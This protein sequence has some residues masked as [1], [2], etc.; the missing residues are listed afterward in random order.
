LFLHQATELKKYA[1]YSDG[2]KKSQETGERKPWRKPFCRSLQCMGNDL[3]AEGRDGYNRTK[4]TV[5]AKRS[6][7]RGRDR[8]GEKNPTTF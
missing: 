1:A 7:K 2:V 4:R 6:E 5:V 8:E 3:G